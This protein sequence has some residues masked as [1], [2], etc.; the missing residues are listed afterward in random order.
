MNFFSF[1]VF[2]SFF[3]RQFFLFFLL[4]SIWL[5]NQINRFFKRLFFQFIIFFWF[6]V[7]F[8][9]LFLIDQTIFLI[10]QLKKT[11]KIEL[12][13][14]IFKSAFKVL[15]KIIIEFYTKSI[16]FVSELTSSSNSRKIKNKKK[17]VRSKTTF[18]RFQNSGL[19]MNFY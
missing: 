4:D 8:V 5:K 6:I 1:V 18:F 17:S 13:S 2:F 10:Y 19:L 14:K 9:F 15:I 3:V 16:D 12:K 11:Q 7:L